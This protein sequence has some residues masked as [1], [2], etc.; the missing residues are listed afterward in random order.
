[1]TSF[2]RIESESFELRGT[3]KGYLVQLSA[4]NRD[5][6][7]RSGSV[8]SRG[9]AGETLSYPTNPQKEVAVKWRLASTPK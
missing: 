8:W 6:T 7:A 2:H 5:P 4:M 3:I 9:G 1:M